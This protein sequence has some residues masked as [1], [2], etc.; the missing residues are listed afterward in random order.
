MVQVL[1]ETEK[2]I[3]K[4]R[5]SHDIKEINKVLHSILFVPDVRVKQN[6]IEELCRYLTFKLS[7]P[8]YKLKAFIAQNG[9][10]I[11]GF[12]ICQ[13]DPYYTSYSRKCGIFGWLH[14]KNLNICKELMREC[15]LFIK[16]HK[17]RKLRGNINFPKNLGGIGIQTSGFNQQILYGVAF[18]SP[19]S[20]VIDYLEE[21]GYIRESQY[22]CVYVAQ[23]TWEKGK[24]I[25]KDIVFKYVNLKKLYDLVDEI[26]ALANNS[27]HE[28]LPDASGRNR[29]Y[30]FFEAFKQIPKSWYRIQYDFN[31]KS[32]SDIPHFIEAWE[33]CDLK[34]IEPLAPMAF[35]RKTGELVG[36]LLG[37]PDLYE[38]WIG[39]PITRVNVDTA[40][41]KKGY[42]GK[43]IFSAL[44]NLG[45]LTANLFGVNYFEGTAIW[46][47]NSRAID[48]IFPHCTPIRK[49]YVMQKRI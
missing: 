49:H 12:V 28:I 10:E 27:F 47:N 19:Q 15:E 2:D 4:V 48:T 38:S 20:K 37:L 21:L 44:N 23:K 39:D 41:V 46:S 45:Q 3:I 11:C 16:K 43:G 6:I 8:E 42:F 26:R 18:N 22:T 36:I 17:V 34:K 35:D 1:Y 30:E 24:R 33:S 40:M 25:D 14:A 29:I 13:I 9:L 7:N 31:P 32:Y 5:E